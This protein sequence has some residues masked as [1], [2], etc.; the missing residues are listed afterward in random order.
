MS[1]CPKDAEFR[2]PMRR[3]PRALVIA[4]A[5]LLC[6]GCQ[7]VHR[8]AS[9]ALLFEKAVITKEHVDEAARIE[10]E[11]AKTYRTP[12]PEGEPWFRTLPGTSRVLVVAGHATAHMRE[13]RLKP[14]DRGTGSLAVMLNKLAGCPVIYTT[15]QSPSDPNY[16]DDND[17]KKTLS[18][19][20]N[21]YRP[22][23]VLDLHASHFNRPY[24]VDFGT[25]GGE[26]LLGRPR[27]LQ[28]LASSLKKEGLSNFSQEFFAAAK[29]QTITKW[30]ARHGIPS[31]QNEFNSTWLL[32]RDGS[33]EN[34]LQRQR[35]AQLLQAL[36]RFVRAVD[37]HGVT[38][39]ILLNVSKGLLLP[40]G[41]EVSG[42]T[43]H[44]PFGRLGVG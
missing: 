22:V 26:S 11:L 15:F 6:A 4:L 27:L 10:A 40:V 17:F 9:T 32:P 2:R 8:D 21:E 24:D 42:D 35:F 1:P 13:G 38:S 33:N 28:L 18:E 34:G 19:L 23:V 37:R 7:L 5:T 36:V 31:I 25:M 3:T 39:S 41:I 20:I 30:V 29:H 43:V 12:P 44:D 14:E 16:Y